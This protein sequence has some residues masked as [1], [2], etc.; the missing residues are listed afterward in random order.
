M[1]KWKARLNVHG[2]QQEYGANYLETYSPVVKWFSIR[3]LLNMASINKCHSI[4]VD[5][6][7]LY[8]QSPIKYDLYMELPKGFQTKE[9]DGRTHVLQFLKN[10]YRQK[11]VG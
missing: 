6:I 9:G 2:G 5:F 3:N 11:Q 10:I 7:K 8:P 4:Q 1:Y